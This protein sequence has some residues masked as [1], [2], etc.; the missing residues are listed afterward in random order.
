[1]EQ[2]KRR[3]TYAK[4]KYYEIKHSAQAQQQPSTPADSKYR[5]KNTEL[6]QQIKKLTLQ[7]YKLADDAAQWKGKLVQ[8]L[9]LNKM[10]REEGEKV[11]RQIRRLVERLEMLERREEERYQFEEVRGQIEEVIRKEDKLRETQINIE[12]DLK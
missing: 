7:T 12:E 2:Y 3:A 9:Q 11:S 10:Q 6:K 4:T 5:L 1:M 8:A